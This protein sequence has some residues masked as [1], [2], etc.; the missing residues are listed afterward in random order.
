MHASVFRKRYIWLTLF[1]LDRDFMLYS[2]PAA[3]NPIGEKLH[4]LVILLHGD[5]HVR[6]YHLT[7]VQSCLPNL[8]LA[9]CA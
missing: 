3:A 5:D 1:P 4:E 9:L 7:M 6:E 2:L 8:R